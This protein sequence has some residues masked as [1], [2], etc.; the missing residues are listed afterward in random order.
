MSGSSEGSDRGKQPE[1]LPPTR[2]A[3]APASFGRPIDAGTADNRNDT[4]GSLLA[5]IADILGAA[6]RTLRI[7]DKRAWGPD[8]EEQ[9][10]ALEETLDE[11]R[12]DFQ[13]LGP[14]VSGL[15]G[16]KDGDKKQNPVYYEND[17]KGKSPCIMVINLRY[18]WQG[19]DMLTAKRRAA[20]SIKEL[21]Q[22][23]SRFETHT[24]T[25]KAWIRT[26]GPINPLWMR[27][28]HA[29]RRE[30]HRAQRRAARRI[31][32]TQQSAG[33]GQARC[34]AA[35]LIK[36]KQRWGEQQRAR[37]RERTRARM[38]EGVRGESRERMVSS[39]YPAQGPGPPPPVM[40]SFEGSIAN[41]GNGKAAAG[42]RVQELEDVVEEET[43][44]QPVA[45]RR[46][47]GLQRRPRVGSTFTTTR[48]PQRRTS[49]E[50]LVPE[51]NAVGHFERLGDKNIA[52]ICDYCDGFI[53]W[54]DLDVMPS[55]RTPT[56]AT[57]APP[58]TDTGQPSDA[59]P[60][61]QAT[62]RSRSTGEDKTVVFAPLAIANHC[63][64]AT[65]DWQSRIYCPFCDDY[66]YYGQGD[67]EVERL[68]YLQD[69]AGFSDLAS[70]QE[71]LAWQHS[72]VARPAAAAF[73]A[74]IL[75]TSVSRGK[76]VMM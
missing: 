46:S 19:Q 16:R 58:V 7:A 14:L 27:D 29:L 55:T 47:S 72:E 53:V 50:E 76:C 49:L 20:E 25:F 63:A 51:C 18:S 54:E 8:E 45:P 11:A 62:G 60:N 68:K 38:M 56:D 30:L 41:H 15:D 6:L 40:G 26:G 22:L 5:D 31:F 65:I 74:A 32:D 69:D 3:T 71:H 43:N 66:E 57:A 52:F 9:V 61:W 10:R 28:T 75:P 39:T 23:R 2:F 12:R 44:G 34:L 35:Y 4:V 67:D 17:R 70:F 42:S 1:I 59:Y 37:E 21:R 33:D 73:A 24:H 13:F 48:G 36:K 64:P